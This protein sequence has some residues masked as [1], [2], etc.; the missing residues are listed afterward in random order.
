MLSLDLSTTN[1]FLTT[2]VIALFILFIALLVKLHPSKET[3]KNPEVEI[4]VEKQRTLQT[5]IIPDNPPPMRVEPPRVSEKPLIA[6]SPSIGGPSVQ[7]K[8]EIAAS[9]CNGGRE[10]PKQERIHIQAKNNSVPLKKDCPHHFGYLRTFPK[11]SPIP[12]E[13]FDCEKIVDCL[14][15][16]K[17]R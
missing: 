16:K 1:I 3:K 11:N 5:P 6:V 13:C 9:T 4:E 15:Y 2:A 7:V 17:S 10:I 12:D 8:Q 14:V